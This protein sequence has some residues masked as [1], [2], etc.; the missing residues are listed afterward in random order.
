MTKHDTAN[1][2][3]RSMLG[4]AVGL[5]AA[6]TTTSAVAVQSARAAGKADRLDAGLLDLE[7]QFDAQ[8]PVYLASRAKADASEE[9]FK[10]ATKGRRL[11]MPEWWKLRETTGT[12]AAGQACN[13]EDDKLEAIATAVRA[14]RPV[15]FA[16]LM[17]WVKVTAYSTFALHHFDEDE[18][19]MD[20]DNY[21]MLLLYR[22]VER[23]AREEVQA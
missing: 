20:W 4:L 3:R 21:T 9:A 7:R 17:V 2:G 15:T 8:W 22:E 12:E 1:P 16:G 11:K 18:E 19:E 6:I 14:I 23:L 10:A 13:D 5:T